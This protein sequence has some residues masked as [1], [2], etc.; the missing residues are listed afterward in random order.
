VVQV[1]K[2][3]SAID[4]NH[5]KS[6]DKENR[7]ISLNASSPI[8]APYRQNKRGKQYTKKQNTHDSKSKERRNIRAVEMIPGLAAN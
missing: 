8:T 5:G 1:A 4:C 6:T 7:V 3:R 2:I